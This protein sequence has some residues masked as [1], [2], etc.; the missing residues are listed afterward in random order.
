M[1]LHSTQLLVGND[2]Q[3]CM[4]ALTSGT[5]DT[6]LHVV[7]RIELSFDLGLCILPEPPM[8]MPKVTLDGSLPSLQVFF[9]DRKYKAVMSTIDLIVEGLNEDEPDLTGQFETGSPHVQPTAFGAGGIFSRISETPV[10]SEDPALALQADSDD[11]KSVASSVDEFFE[12]TEAIAGGE[13]AATLRRKKNREGR[14]KAGK[15][16]ERPLVR[17][18]FSVDNLVGFIWR[19]HDDG[20]DDLHIADLAVTGLAVEVVNRP[21]DLFAN[22][23]IHQI[24]IEDHL[25]LGGVPGSPHV[26]AL[27]SDIAQA[28]LDGDTDKNLVVVKYHRCQGDHPEFT[29]TYESIGQT[30]DVD[31]SYLDLMVVRRT[32]LTCYDF[33]LKTFTDEAKKNE[34]VQLSNADDAQSEQ[35]D[36]MVD[37]LLQ[38]ALDTIRVDVKFKGT[39]FSLCHDDGMPV[40]LL[41]VTA[42]AVRVTVTEEVVVEAKVGNIMLVDQLDTVP[43]T[44]GS[45]GGHRQT[46]D[47]IDP[48]RLL[49]YVK[50]DELADFRYQT[51]DPRSAGFP[52]YNSA[53][54]L[55]V[56]AAHLA[57]VERP[58]LELMLFG[59]R[60]FAMHGLFEAARQAAAYGT[61]QLTEEM[62]GSGQKVHFD[63]VMSAPVIT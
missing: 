52:G 55:R 37:S 27:T 58:I 45:L 21:F 36:K 40:A 18:T 32:I 44:M 2:L 47:E 17:V 22:V 15:E 39:D 4:R 23:T 33:I 28:D 1:Q 60:F 25:M 42:A 16:P 50:G 34:R 14:R 13:A 49:L 24:T 8:H 43:A 59:S 12:T 29:T 56:G 51:F 30:V 61:S 41:S 63:I 20:R 5:A 57:F 3:A 48:N 9:S 31:I 62:I 6:K 11:A 7:D 19:T 46:H 53:L 35:G 54:K 38:Q 10:D 26:Y